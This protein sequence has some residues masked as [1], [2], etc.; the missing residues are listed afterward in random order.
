MDF[1]SD[2]LAS[3]QR[4]RVLNVADDFTRENLVMYV[5]TSLTG[6]DVVR[7]F[8]EVVTRRG[9]PAALLTDNGPEFISKALDHS[10][11]RQG[12]RHLFIPPGKPVENA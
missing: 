8:A 4:F 2:Q 11:H 7:Q 12:I 5:G 9:Q 1:M 3:G 6:A 10:V